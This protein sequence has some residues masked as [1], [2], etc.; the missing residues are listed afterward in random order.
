M[1]PSSRPRAVARRDRAR[2]VLPLHQPVLVAR[3]VRHLDRLALEHHAPEVLDRERRPAAQQRGRVE[4]HEAGLRVE[5][6]VQRRDVAVA[7]HDLGVLAD[8]L[9][10]DERQHAR[11]A[12]AAPDR[13]DAAH[14]RIGEER[15]HVGGAVRVA[16]GQV[17][18]A[19]PHVRPE[20]RLEREGAHDVLGDLDVHRL[21][22]GR[23]G[24]D[25]AHAVA[26]LQSPRAHRL[27]RAA[28]R[29]QP[30][31]LGAAVASSEP[32]PVRLRNARRRM[33]RATFRRRTTAA[34]GCAWCAARVRLRAA[35]GCELTDD[36]GRGDVAVEAAERLHVSRGEPS[37]STLS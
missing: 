36:R 22:V 8:E 35:S 2:A 16:A 4:A 20:P 25:Q 19:V 33:P 17:A 23:G 29:P 12:P 30:S 6:A 11:A 9:P 13:E 26:R 21:E 34:P 31:R 7:G 3:R 1:P 18:V 14:R 10:V 15:V 24:G 28:R 5:A 37:I 27:E 32:A